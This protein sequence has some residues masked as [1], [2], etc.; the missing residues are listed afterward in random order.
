[1]PAPSPSRPPAP[2]ALLT[3]PGDGGVDKEESVV[4]GETVPAVGLVL[5]LGDLAPLRGTVP[6]DDGQQDSH[7]DTYYHQHH[8]HVPATKK[9]VDRQITNRYCTVFRQVRDAT[10]KADKR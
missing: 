10:D 3:L 2:S 5:S 9:T 7:D 1:M 8:P 4:D 6:V